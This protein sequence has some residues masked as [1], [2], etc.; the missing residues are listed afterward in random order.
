MFNG[1]TSEKDKWNFI[2][3]ARN[4][5]RSNVQIHSLRNC[6]GDTV[7]D[8]LRMANLLNYRFSKL[9]DYSGV[10]KK[11]ISSEHLINDEF[12]F[13]PI[14]IYECRKQIKSL[15]INKPLGPS[16]I[17]AWALKDAS[18]VLAEP[19]T[20]LINAFLEEGLFPNHLKQAYVIPIFKKGDCEESCNYRPISITPA[21]S[22]IFEKI[23]KDQMIAFL[24]RNNVLSPSQFGFQAGFSSTDALHFATENIR[25][26]IDQNEHV[27][28]AF[29]DLS[30]AFDSISHSILLEKLRELNFNKVAIS[31]IQSYLTGR[32]QKV[33]LNN[34]KSDWIE[35]H[36]GVP[37]GTILGP[38]LFNIYVNRMKEFITEKCELIQYAD[39]TMIFS[40][41][42]NEK[43][44]LKNLEENIK[45][46]KN[47]FE[48]H[49]LTINADKTEFITF[50]KMS[51]NN[52][53]R[54]MESHVDG[55]TIPPSNH[56]KYLGVFLDKN[57]AYQDEVKNLLMKMACGIKTIY[58]VRDLF[59]EKTRFLLLNALVISHLHYS[60]VLLNGI[61]ENLL[62]TLEK[63]LSWAVKACFNRNKFDHSSDLKIYH[64]ILP[65]RY[66][67]QYKS[68]LYFWKFKHGI[69]PAFAK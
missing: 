65:I 22:K 29:L 44:A 32:N 21:L 14:S 68:V 39:D 24:N 1:F 46:I 6:F 61:T 31:L 48:I 59:P 67:L 19:L 42:T 11:F 15:N 49:R 62:T 25:K 23:I 43:E 58:S 63:Q 38:L 47:F 30:K 36:Q 5:R 10:V 60:S 54:D 28:A 13:Q 53:V 16:N 37:Q 34:C 57:L 45:K 26:K 4:T 7:T 17:P 35:I 3:E 56:V 55:K 9:G 20:F 50:C 8:D 40:A 33:M 52:I 27:T 69:L 51:K 64:K 66:F 18:D 41:N 12:Q 2:N